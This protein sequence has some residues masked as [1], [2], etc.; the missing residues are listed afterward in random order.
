MTITLRAHELVAHPVASPLNCELSEG[1][2][3]ILGQREQGQT[4]LAMTLAGRRRP[5]SGSIALDGNPRTRNLFRC[6][7]L[8]GAREIDSLERLVTV[9]TV[10]REQVAWA[11]PWYRIA[12]RDITASSLVRPWLE[13]LG[14]ELDQTELVG[15][16]PPAQRLRLRVLLGLIARPKAAFLVV[17]DIDQ[18]RSLDLVEDFLRDLQ[19]VSR[20]LPV[21][22]FGVNSHYAHLADHVVE[23]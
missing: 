21:M 1:L 8:A 20:S 15:D 9:R 10:V 14:L 7:A 11:Q 16:L 12:P 19:K 2:N 5:V 18:L 4:A 17:D 6:A 23:V 13:P 3:L 22:A